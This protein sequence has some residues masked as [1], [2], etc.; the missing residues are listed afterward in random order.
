MEEVT[1]SLSFRS[2][3]SG[4]SPGK[5]Q[6]THAP[7]ELGLCPR[8]TDGMFL[9]NGLLYTFFTKKSIVNLTEKPGAANRI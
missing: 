8:D 6:N 1:F 9:Y 5:R 2:L 7:D 4:I 3:S